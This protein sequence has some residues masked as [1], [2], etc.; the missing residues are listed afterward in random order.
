MQCEVE[1]SAPPS[2]QLRD[3]ASSCQSRGSF[4]QSIPQ[5]CSRDG[6]LPAILSFD[7]YPS[8]EGVHF[9]PTL[10]KHLFS[11]DHCSRH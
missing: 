10:I 2:G 8:R 7:L 6:A 1:V 5:T 4:V 9:R 11:V 3:F